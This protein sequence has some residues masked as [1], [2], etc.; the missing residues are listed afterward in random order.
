[1][2]TDQPTNTDF[3]NTQLGAF[4][5]TYSSDSET[6]CT[7][8][9]YEVEVAGILW[10]VELT[11]EGRKVSLYA[12]NSDGANRHSR[13]TYSPKLTLGTALANMLR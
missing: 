9:C 7:A 2:A 10:T 6:W 1:M 11:L 5:F 12:Y 13:D 8:R 4:P 3:A